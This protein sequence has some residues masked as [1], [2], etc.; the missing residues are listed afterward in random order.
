MIQVF[1]TTQQQIGQRGEDIAVLYIESKDFK[2]IQRNYATQNGELD[3]I[4]IKDNV[5]YFIEVKTTLLKNSNVLDNNRYKPEYN[6]S[7]EK[8]R[9]MQLCAE[10]YVFEE[11]DRLF[12]LDVS[13]E[14]RFGAIL[15]EIDDRN[16][17]SYVRFMRN[18]IIENDDYGNKY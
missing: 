15:I 12:R 2:V 4:A 10:T 11:N 9:K 7:R 6:V 3:L 13:C 14:T 16:N 1:T 17:R 5:L 8:L 18:I